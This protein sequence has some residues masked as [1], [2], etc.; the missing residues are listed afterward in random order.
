MRKYQHR[1]F[2]TLLF[3]TFMFELLVVWCGVIV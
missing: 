3:L 1:S 2:T